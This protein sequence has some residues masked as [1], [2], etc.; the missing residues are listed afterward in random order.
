MRPYLPI[1]VQDPWSP[2]TPA[3]DA[4]GISLAAGRQVRRP[5]RLVQLVL[6]LGLLLALVVGID[7]ASAKPSAKAPKSAL[8]VHAPKGQDR[9]QKPR[10]LLVLQRISLPDIPPAE[11]VKRVRG[12]VALAEL[13]WRAA[14][15]AFSQVAAEARSPGWEEKLRESERVLEQAGEALQSELERATGGAESS[16]A[17]LPGYYWLCWAELAH[18]AALQR[19]ALEEAAN[20][21]N[22]PHEPQPDLRLPARWLDTFLRSFGKHPLR[23]WALY[24]RAVIASEWYGDKPAGYIRGLQQLVA[25]FPDHALALE[26]QLRLA[27]AHADGTE[28][29]ATQLARRALKAAVQRCAV[30]PAPALPLRELK[31][32]ESTQR[33]LVPRELVP[34]EL[35]LCQLARFELA[36]VEYRAGRL[37]AAA[38]LLLT[39]LRGAPA[40]DL[41]RDLA[42]QAT[43]MLRQIALEPGGEAVILAADSTQGVSR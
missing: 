10:V 34:R 24:H 43:E 21:E 39:I 17:P 3:V 19:L 9:V 25:E 35:T 36:R 5:S 31:L 41:L 14:E 4:A 12:Q 8:Q 28:P 7:P 33:E 23:P 32:P 15:R 37:A 40:D 38:R 27:L 18:R 26:A 1:F 16:A 2:S 13:H 22:L 30:L 20:P 42:A 11:D 29:R 6:R